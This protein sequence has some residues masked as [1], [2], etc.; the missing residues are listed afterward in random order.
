MHFGVAFIKKPQNLYLKAKE[1]LKVHS[2]AHKDIKYKL[3]R[4]SVS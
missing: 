1:I 2:C 4:V 3:F